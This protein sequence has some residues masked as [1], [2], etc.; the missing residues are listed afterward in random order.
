MQYGIKQYIFVIR[1]LTAREI[2]RKY[3]RSVLGIVWS[4]LNPLL[5]MV[6]M[7]IVFS[8][9]FNSASS[10]PVYY[11]I[12]YTFWTM[13]STG[14]ASAMSALEDNKTLFQK[15]KLPR[16]IFVLSRVYTALVNLGFSCIAMILVLLIFKVEISIYAIFFVV[17]VSFE[18]LFTIGI[19]YI[20][21]VIYVFY[22]DIR[23]LWQNVLILLVH[24]VA[25]FIPIERYPKEL[26]VLTANNPL[27][28]FPD[29]ARQAIMYQE[30]NY[31]ELQKMIIWGMCT[32][33]MGILV[34]KISENN[35]V[36]KI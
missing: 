10:Y 32:F 9:F 30:M 8:N 18:L 31:I 35:L 23:F 26:Y 15:T 24:M 7:S 22:K 12:S 28:I 19:S 21:A 34:F 33:L 14:S 17:A 5:F 27:F 29:I 16:S 11:I 20:L 3:S 1:E 25:I 4:V 2:K 6:V 13:F 36:K